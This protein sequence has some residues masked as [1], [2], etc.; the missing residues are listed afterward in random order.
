M[1]YIKEQREYMLT[2]V[3]K[4]LNEDRDRLRVWKA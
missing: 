4:P 1:A 3:S 2:G